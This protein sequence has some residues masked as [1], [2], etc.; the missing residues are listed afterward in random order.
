MKQHQGKTDNQPEEGVML[1]EKTGLPSQRQ[2]S[3][4]SWSHNLM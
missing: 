1:G 4:K 3:Q 2:G